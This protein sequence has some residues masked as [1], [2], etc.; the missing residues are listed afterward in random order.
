MKYKPLLLEL[1]KAAF[2]QRWNDQLRFVDL[3]ELDKQAHKMI[4]AFI[5][6]KLE[7]VDDKTWVE[8]IEA[9]I[10]EFLQRIIITDIKPPLFYRIKQDKEKYN[11]LNEFVCSEIKPYIGDIEDGAFFLRFREYIFSEQETLSRKIIRASHFYATRWEFALIERSNPDGYETQKIKNDLEKLQESTYDLKSMQQFILSKDLQN[12]SDLCSSLRFQIRWNHLHRVP[13]TSVLGHMLIVA[14]IVYFF[15][16][17][18]K[19]CEKRKFNN[20]CTALFHDLPEVLT[21]DIISP[22]KRSVEGLDEFI[23]EYE[24]EEM[25][26]IYRLLPNMFHNEIRLFTE[27]EFSNIVIDG[28]NILD[29]SSKEINVKYNEN[30]YNPRDGEL[31]QMAD[32]LAAFVE[33]K[34][35]IDNGINNAEL[36]NAEQFLRKSYEDN[37][38]SVIRIA[39]IYNEFYQ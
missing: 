22:I 23:K 36:L 20:F 25:Q 19:A 8:I 34:L 26:K 18:V 10:F 5:L 32:K 6:G 15:S 7:N 1:F 38:A 2:M 24:K 28:Q 30:K 11:R 13:K 33:A 21:R 9:G 39:D 12:F 37:T 35:A 17:E 3:F 31:V 27:N 16:L 4:I 29:V 14:I